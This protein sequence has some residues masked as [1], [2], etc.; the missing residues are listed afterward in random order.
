MS[1]AEAEILQCFANQ[2]HEPLFDDREEHATNPR[3]RWFV[4]ETDYGRKLKVVYVPRG[5]DIYVKSAYDANAKYVRI[6][7]ENARPL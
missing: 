1:V 3:T 4:G 2:T 5:Y 6:Y 7:S